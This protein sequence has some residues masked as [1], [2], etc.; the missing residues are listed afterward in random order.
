[1]N[2]LNPWRI[3]GQ[4]TIIYEIMEKMRPDFISFPAGNLGN[5]SAFGKALIEMK[6]MG[7]IDYV[8]R[9]IAVQAEGASP[10][11]NYINNHEETLHPVSGNG[12]K[13]HKN[14][15]SGELY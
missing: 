3:E 7:M 10:F 8:P 15:K 9:L 14:R 6:E 12:C 11:Y 13:C 2:S 5:T 4:K 1:M